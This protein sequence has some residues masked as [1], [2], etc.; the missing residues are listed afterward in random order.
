MSLGLYFIDAKAADA[1]P[2]EV[3]AHHCDSYENLVDY[4]HCLPTTPDADGK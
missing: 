3:T 1:S 2:S 4:I